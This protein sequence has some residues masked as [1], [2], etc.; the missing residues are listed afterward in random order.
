M[1]DSCSFALSLFSRDFAA[2]NVQT[3]L[4]KYGQLKPGRFLVIVAGHVL[5]QQLHKPPGT[6]VQVEDSIQLAMVTGWLLLV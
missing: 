1:G 3:Q 4:A 5:L 2:L 6:G